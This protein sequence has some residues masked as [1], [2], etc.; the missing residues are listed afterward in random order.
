VRV[1]ISTN[2][3]GYPQVQLDAN[4]KDYAPDLAEDLCQ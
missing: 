4:P 3:H 1:R 2:Q